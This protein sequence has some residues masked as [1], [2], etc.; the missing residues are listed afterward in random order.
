V[1]A[2]TSEVEPALALAVVAETLHDLSVSAPGVLLPAFS[3]AR[4]TYSLCFSTTFPLAATTKEHVIIL[5]VI[6]V[7]DIGCYAFARKSLSLALTLTAEG[8]VD[9]ATN[10]PYW[11]PHETAPTGFVMLLEPEEFLFLFWVGHALQVVEGI[12]FST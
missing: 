12:W 2:L 4:R 10:L 11:L 8:L 7:R 9:E 3:L 1:G 6:E 5:I